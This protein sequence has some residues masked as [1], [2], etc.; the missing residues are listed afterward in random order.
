[1]INNNICNQCIKTEVCKIYDILIK[2]DSDAKKPLGVNITMNSCLNFD[3]GEE[4]E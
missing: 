1:M 4:K 2:F 3:C